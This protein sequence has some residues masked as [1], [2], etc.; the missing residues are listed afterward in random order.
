ML[1]KVPLNFTIES[2][3]K[4][5]PCAN[6]CRKSMENA[7]GT[8]SVSYFTHPSN[9]IVHPM[10]HACKG[11]FALLH[12]IFIKRCTMHHGQASRSMHHALAPCTMH[13]LL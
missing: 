13:E 8:T 10:G 4:D 5:A 7:P 3:L 11:S 6:Y 12:Q 2:W 1:V 9:F